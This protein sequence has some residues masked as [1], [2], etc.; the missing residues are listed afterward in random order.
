[1]VKIVI[2]FKRKPGMSVE[3]FQ[4]HWRSIHAGI[5]SRLPGIRRYVQNATLASGYRKGEPAFDAVA[6]SSF[7]DTQAMKALART[8]EY[9]RV[10]ADEPNFID[11][12]SMGSIITDEHVIKDAP[13]PREGVKSI[14]FVTHRADLPV[15]EFFH[16][17]RDVHGPLCRALPEVRRYVQSHTRP[18]IYESGRVPAY[19]GV[20][21]SWYDSTQ[22]LKEAAGTPGFAALRADV[23]KFVDRS[24]SPF[25]LTTERVVLG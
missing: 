19:D 5:I 16:Y 3:A 23:E 9:A 6:E 21:M 7:D 14:D 8:P 11:A 20:A 13:A 17:W 10:L 12:A 15:K 24:R 4:E 25:V 1:M 2:F 22:A 18:S